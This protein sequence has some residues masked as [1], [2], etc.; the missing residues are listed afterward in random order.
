[1]KKFILVLMLFVAINLFC[2]ETETITDEK[3]KIYIAKSMAEHIIDADFMHFGYVGV[4]V[5]RDS[6]AKESGY[7]YDVVS[8]YWGD[9]DN[10]IAYGTLKVQFDKKSSY[11]VEYGCSGGELIIPEDYHET[12]NLMRDLK[13]SNIMTIRLIVW[14]GKWITLKISLKGFT[15]A[16][17]KM[18]SEW[19]KG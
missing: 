5:W 2:W 6:W 15:K 7:D 16:Y 17:N 1:M 3:G 8:I 11:E 18:L 12:T 10:D 13:D 4:T 19:R 9:F 14:N